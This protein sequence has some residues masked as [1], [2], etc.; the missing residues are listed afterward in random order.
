MS[1]WRK[2]SP[3]GAIRDF[4]SEFTRPN[5]YRWPVIGLSAV[6][7]FTIFSVM[8]Q[9]GA[10]GPPP[11]PEVTFI[12]TF[13]PHRSDAEIIASN[14][15]NQA[16]NDRFAAEQA[17]RDEKVK[18][19]YRTLG[20]ASGMDVDKIERQ[21]AAEREAEKRAEEKRYAGRQDGGVAPE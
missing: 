16:K 3:T 14:K 5:P 1:F 11:R 8:W 21:A 17:A 6:A 13:A 9:E 18:D 4:V 20:R 2:I 19:I 10:E 12:T 15:A 7:T